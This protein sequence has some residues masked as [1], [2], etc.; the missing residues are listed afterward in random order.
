MVGRDRALQLLDQVLALVPADQAEATLLVQDHA[1]TR[2]A[3]NSIHQNVARKDARL[4]VRAVVDGRVGAAMTNLLDGESQRRVAE[5]AATIARLQ[6]PDPD[7]P[8]L[9]AAR[10]PREAMTYY[11]ATAATTP[12]QRAQAVRVVVDAASRL[13]FQATGACATEIEELAIAST[14][15]VAA[16]APLTLA[17]LR[18]VVDAGHGQG[19]GVLTGYADA[20]S[21][22][23]NQIGPRVVAAR[24]VEKCALN[25][26]PHL[27]PAG[28]YVTILEEIAVADLLRFLARLGLSAQAV[29][30]GRSFAVG[31]MGQPV[32]GENLTLWDDAADA[33]GLALP[34]DWEGMPAERLELVSSGVLRG[35]A[36]DSRS[37][38]REGR[39]STGHA[40]S[41]L[42]E[43]WN[44]WPAPPTC[45]L[46]PAMWPARTSSPAWSRASSSPAFTIPTAPSPSGWSL[47]ARRAM[48]PFSS[49][50]EPSPGQSAI[51]ASPKVSSR[52][53]PTS[54]PS[55]AALSCTGIGGGVRRTTCPPCAS[56][57][58][59]WPARQADPGP[60]A[61]SPRR[62][63]TMERL[64]AI[65]EEIRAEFEAKNA[66]RDVALQRSRTLIRHCA[67]GIRATHRG[68][69]DEALDLLRI[70]GEA[71]RE[72]TADLKGYPDLYQA[73]YT[74]DAL[75]EYVEA[76]VVHSLI[77]GS[78]LPAPSELGVE[79]A[80]YLKGLAEAASEMRRHALE[81]MRQNR[82][83]RAE[84][85]M[86]IMDDIYALL[87]TMDF[88][89]AIT[90]GLRRVTDMLRGVV[91]R[92]RG[93][94]TTAIRQEMM[95]QALRDFEARIGMEGGS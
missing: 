77:R 20:I 57:I 94:L 39:P 45:S 95:R 85:I 28:R 2:F 43:R 3:N 56:A 49:R 32:C 47:R 44:P 86:G 22:D 12:G 30:E 23:V 59:A 9:P 14:T 91:E 82:L 80:A 69:F 78:A 15:G 10:A 29:H 76:E 33:R 38:A 68:D 31:K 70:A 7:F 36:H 55:A 74:Q 88:P 41:Q 84:E 93:D 89:D 72:M 63:E 11:E 90:E 61:S 27:L 5:Q 4:A 58:L 24:A 26:D 16:Y 52:P 13:G 21:R 51:C 25:R 17:S 60:R 54:R 8:G 81:L 73:G 67:N 62:E 75:K 18:T 66:V 87:M 40:M 92:T 64:E 79:A 42:F 19:I 50:T 37:A 6:A 34:F 1:L 53:W 71:A 46:P 35:L 65:V 83:E 48:A